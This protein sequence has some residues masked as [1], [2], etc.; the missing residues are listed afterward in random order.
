MCYKQ[1]WILLEGED[2]TRFF[3]N[4]FQPILEGIYGLGAIQTWEYAQRKQEKVINLLKSIKA[5]NANYIFVVDI[6]DSTCATQRKDLALAKYRPHLDQNN[7]LV[8]KK[9]IESWYI[10]GVDTRTCGKL[11]I[12]NHSTTENISKESF[13]SLQPRTYISRKSFM[14][15]ILDS[16]CIDTAKQKNTSFD[17]FLNK[18]ISPM[19]TSEKERL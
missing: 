13:N 3:E 15:D 19:T 1:F 8:V 14:K 10:A 4:I 11:K 6:D 5:M 18:Y 12:P 7:I 16:F 2:D 9:E 17:Y